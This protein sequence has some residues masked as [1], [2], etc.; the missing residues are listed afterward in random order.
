MQVVFK[1]RR[2]LKPK[3]VTLFLNIIYLNVNNFFKSEYSISK[4]LKTIQM[5]NEGSEVGL[6]FVTRAVVLVKYI[7][8]K[9]M[10]PS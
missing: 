5:P 8:M 7:R 1:K 10:K 2:R 6:L 4:M 3:N 9:M